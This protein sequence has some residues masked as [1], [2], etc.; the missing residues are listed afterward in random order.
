MGKKFETITNV[1]YRNGLDHPD[2]P[3]KYAY[4]L[5]SNGETTRERYLTPEEAAQ[6][7]KKIDK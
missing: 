7:Q 2:H 3:E 5:E 4:V 1:N 6:M